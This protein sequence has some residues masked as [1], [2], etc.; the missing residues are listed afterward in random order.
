MD[1]FRFDG[2]HQMEPLPGTI[3]VGY[4]NGQW[5]LCLSG[6]IDHSVVDAFERA[7]NGRRAV[8]VETIDAATVTFMSACGVSLMLR[9]QDAATRLGHSVTLRA[10]SRQVD[11]LLDLAGVRSAFPQSAHKAPVAQES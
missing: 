3:T 10:S 8:A 7:Q 4:Q 11:R 1:R 9:C 2:Q 6:E 5:V